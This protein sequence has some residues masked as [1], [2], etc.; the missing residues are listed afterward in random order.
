M[1]CLQLTAS[2]TNS[3]LLLAELAQI[4]ASHPTELLDIDQSASPIQEKGHE[5]GQA[6]LLIETPEEDPHQLIS[7][8]KTWAGSRGVQLETH[9][10]SKPPSLSQRSVRNPLQANGNTSVITLI[11]ESL[12]FAALSETCKALAAHQLEIQEIQRLSPN[13][14]KKG[15]NESNESEERCIELIASRL[16]KPL[17]SPSHPEA[18]IRATLMTIA[19][20]H[21]MDIAIQS[22]GLYRRAKRLI[23]FD[24]DSTLIQNEVIDELAREKG[25]YDQVSEIT[26][27]AMHGEMDY[28]ESLRQRVA[29]LKGLRSDDLE[30]VYRRIQLTP[31][32]QELIEILKGLGYRVGLLSGGFTFVS[33]RLKETL[34][35]D[36]AYA[37]TLAMKDG[38]VSGEVIPPIINAQ[39]KADLLESIAKKE[40]LSLDQT[41]AVGDG[42]NDLLMLEKAGLGIAFNAKPV[43]SARA[44][45]ALHQKNLRTILYLTGDFRRRQESRDTGHPGGS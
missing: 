2:G 21:Q 13:A 4:L 14:T 15:P 17:P 20:S 19:R 40:N 27:N 39:K 24:M 38:A 3:P 18:E 42:A 22:D 34:R 8:L 43:V 28:D 25:V 16:S 26:R 10:F 33:D 7:E 5:N 36:Y 29:L 6:R 32:A 1:A 23:V 41:V 11:G 35:L 37:N 44:D 30:N 31:G 45:L 12:P 9:L